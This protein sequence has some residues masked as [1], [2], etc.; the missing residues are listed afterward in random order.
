MI[1]ISHF[2]YLNLQRYTG[3]GLCGIA[4]S[5]SWSFLQSLQS[6][7]LVSR[8]ISVEWLISNCL[9]I[10]FS[11]LDGSC[12]TTRWTET[13]L[14]PCSNSW[15][16]CQSIVDMSR[17][18]LDRECYGDRLNSVQDHEGVLGRQ[19]HLVWTKFRSHW[20]WKQTSV[21]HL[22]T[23]WIWHDIV[24]HPIGPA[25]TSSDST[26][27]ELLQCCCQHYCALHYYPANA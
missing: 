14:L 19:A 1:L 17:P 5:V 24:C 27:G 2:I 8:P 15:V 25:C 22:H 4:I 18:I 3:T 10:A 26:C 12:H 7:S 9:I 11:Y 16:A 13:E 23:D 21:Y 20:W 6:H